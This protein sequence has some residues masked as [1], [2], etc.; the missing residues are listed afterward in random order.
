M[1]MV[2][3]LVMSCITDNP[4]GAVHIHICTCDSWR[5]RHV[6]CEDHLAHLES[7]HGRGSSPRRGLRPLGSGGKC[8]V[9]GVRVA[10]RRGGGGARA[11]RA[12]AHVSGFSRDGSVGDARLSR[13][14][15]S[16]HGRFPPVRLGESTL[17]EQPRRSGEAARACST[18][19]EASVRPQTTVR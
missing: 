2:C 4:Y 7:R 16:A 6:S 11:E 3:N 19:P 9:R 8:L 17:G 15:V 14:D 10:R 5:V 18:R 13:S 12:S 1:F